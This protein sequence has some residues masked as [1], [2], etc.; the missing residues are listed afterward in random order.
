ML[1]C[2]R[3]SLYPWFPHPTW[4]HGSPGCAASNQVP[5]DWGSTGRWPKLWAPAPTW[6]AWTTSGTLAS[7]WPIPG[8]H[9]H[10]GS[11]PAERWV[12]LSLLPHPSPTFQISEK[13]LKKF[14]W[15]L[16]F[17]PFL[18]VVHYMHALGV[19]HIFMQGPKLIVRIFLACGCFVFSCSFHAVV[20]EHFIL[21]VQVT[22]CAV[23]R[24]T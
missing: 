14:I 7:A 3:V 4:T 20:M 16:I 24:W 5:A 6:E 1:W 8:C 12:S 13:S 21:F 10:V 9:W 19:P 11:D 17:M 18:F 22:L 2:G 15:S 23:M